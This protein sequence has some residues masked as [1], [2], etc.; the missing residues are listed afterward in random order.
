MGEKEY[1]YNYRITEYPDYVRR[2][3]LGYD[4]AMP[5]AHFPFLISKLHPGPRHHLPGVQASTQSLITG[6]V[7]VSSGTKPCDAISPVT[8]LHIYYLNIQRYHYR[9][10]L[11]IASPIPVPTPTRCC[12]PLTDTLCLLKVYFFDTLNSTFWGSSFILPL[13]IFLRVAAT[14]TTTYTTT[15]PAPAVLLGGYCYN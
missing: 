6:I 1:A 9:T 12:S 5:W 3:Y 4:E 8:Q 2:Q 14:T 15:A 7:A 10:T 13:T 11:V